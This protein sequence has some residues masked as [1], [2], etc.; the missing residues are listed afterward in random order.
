VEPVPEFF[1]RLGRLVDRI[2]PLLKNSGAFRNDSTIIAADL[3]RALVIERKVEAQVKA[4]GK[5]N[6]YKGLSMEES[7][8]ADK[9]EGLMEV[10]PGDNLESEGLLGRFEP[11]ITALIEQLEHGKMPDD[12]KLQAAIEDMDPD[13][14]SRWQKL[15][16]LCLRLE[17]LAHKQLRSAAMSKEDRMFIENYGAALGCAMFYDG[18]GSYLDPNDDAP[19]VVDVFA[20]SESGNY[21][22]VGVDRPRELY[23]LYPTKSGEVLCRGA[24]LPYLEFASDSRLTDAQWKALLDSPKRPRLPDWSHAIFSPDITAHDSRPFSPN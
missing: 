15:T 20:N 8:L 19:R 22:T 14:D 5:A 13:L 17:S 9:I 11:R 3:R 4:H 12:R 23:V 21:L 2:R 16:V 6:R 7:T 18:N 1:A 10:F 24:V